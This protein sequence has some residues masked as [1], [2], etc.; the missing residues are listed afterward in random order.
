MSDGH[1]VVRAVSRANEAVFARDW[2]S[3]AEHFSE[4]FEAEDRRPGLQTTYT[5]AENLAQTRVILDLGIIRIDT[6]LVESHNERCALIRQTYVSDTGFVV[7]VLGV[8][9]IDEDGLF[10][11]AVV[12]ED[13][14]LDEARAELARRAQR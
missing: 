12:F 14:D 11:R 1:P 3:V 4:R 7:P 9:E 6:E 8:I 5:K 2:E 10:V 13:D